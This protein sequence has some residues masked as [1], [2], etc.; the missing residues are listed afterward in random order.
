MKREHKFE[1]SLMLKKIQMIRLNL[2]RGGG[3]GN[4]TNGDTTTSVNCPKPTK[5]T[6]PFEPTEPITD[7][8]GN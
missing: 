6:K 3:D 4:V 5:P 8:G 1:K 2:I 7:N